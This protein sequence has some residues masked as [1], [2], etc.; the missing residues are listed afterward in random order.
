MVSCTLLVPQIAPDR[1]HCLLLRLVKATQLTESWLPWAKKT[2]DAA[3]Q[4]TYQ[5]CHRLLTRTLKKDSMD[6]CI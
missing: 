6:L 5:V 3:T 4:T 1:F 2:N